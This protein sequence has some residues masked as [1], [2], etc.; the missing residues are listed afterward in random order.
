MNALSHPLN[1]RERVRRLFNPPAVVFCAL[2]G[3]LVAAEAQL[4]WVERAVGA[5]LAATNAERPESGTIWEKG[6]KAR[7]AQSTV[8]KLASEK[9]SNQRAARNAGTLNEVLGALGPGQG[10]MLSAEHFR[11][12]YQ[13]LPQ[14]FATELI[15]P[16][17]L[18]RLSGEARWNRTYIERSADG[19]M[20]Y[21]L[22][23]GNRVLRQ[24]GISAAALDLL[25][26]RGTAEARSLEELPIFSGRVY[27]AERFFAALADFPEE[28]RR[29]LVPQPEKL[30][31]V[32]GQIYRVG[33]SDQSVSG[34]VELGF[35]LRAGERR[36]VV[37]IQGQDWAVWRLRAVL[38]GRRPG[39]AG[40]GGGPLPEMGGPG[41]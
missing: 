13:R 28:V 25:S 19:V 29:S 9:E 24:F 27:P 5:F 39:A 2:F 8:E 11:E 36:Q 18:L 38:E 16:F 21:L 20:V 1:S 4:A 3:A 6:R 34:F 7:S 37:L 12:I 14:G 40:A 31:D 35:E 17:D 33:I 32:A 15:S 41:S 23:P 22:E 30:L 10:V 26:R